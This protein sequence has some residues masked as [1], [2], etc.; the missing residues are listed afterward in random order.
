MFRP[1]TVDVFRT[2]QTADENGLSLEP[3]NMEQLSSTELDAAT[4][5]AQNELAS[6]SPMLEAES[7]VNR[8]NDLFDALSGLSD[9]EL[10]M[11]DTLLKNKGKKLPDKPSQSSRTEYPLG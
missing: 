6:I 4:Q 1:A 8:D 2:T 3:V 9:Q 7:P 11:L 5:W 10:A